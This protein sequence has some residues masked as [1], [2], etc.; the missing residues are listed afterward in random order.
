MEP[1]VLEVPGSNP[2][3]CFDMDDTVFDF[4]QPLLS[5]YNKTYDD[6]LTLD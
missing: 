5:I 4:M 1:V 6:D 2:V 3:I